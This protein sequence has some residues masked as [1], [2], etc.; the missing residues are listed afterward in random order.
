MRREERIHLLIT[1]F[2][3]VLMALREVLRVKVH[4]K[5]KG[6][7]VKSNRSQEAMVPR[8]RS[9]RGSYPALLDNNDTK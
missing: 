5:E 2:L 8:K 7:K 9:A 4:E 1:I 6:D 3:F